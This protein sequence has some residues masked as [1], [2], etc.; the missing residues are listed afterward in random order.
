MQVCALDCMKESDLHSRYDVSTGNCGLKIMVNIRHSSR[1]F[2][3][4]LYGVYGHLIVCRP[5]YAIQFKTPPWSPFHSCHHV[6]CN[7]RPANRATIESN[8][9]R[10][11]PTKARLP[12]RSNSGLYLHEDVRRLLRALEGLK[13]RNEK[14]SG[15]GELGYVCFMAS[16]VSSGASAL[17][18]WSCTLSSNGALPVLVVLTLTAEAR[19]AVAPKADLAA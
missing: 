1:R 19:L 17:C 18:A 12:V 11:I 16:D 14:M 2:K 8:R 13:A 4:A 10:R 6:F 5:S 7:V 9:S 15:F 3:H